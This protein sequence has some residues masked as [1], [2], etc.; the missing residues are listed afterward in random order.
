MNRLPKDIQVELA[1]E[2]DNSSLIKLCS[3]SSRFNNNIC[4]NNFFWIK[5]LKRE[6]P[7]INI[8]DVTEHKKLYEY[9]KKRAQKGNKLG[10]LNETENAIV[11]KTNRYYQF[12]DNNKLGYVLTDSGINFPEFPPEYLI[13]YTNLFNIENSAKR[14][15]I[16]NKKENRSFIT[17]KF[18]EKYTIIFTDKNSDKIINAVLQNYGS[19]NMRYNDGIFYFSLIPNYDLFYIPK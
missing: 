9:L 17:G 13:K 18:G 6:Y 2:L 12:I 1:L 3:T 11:G 8:T 7:N 10:Q 16:N 4:L 19:T 15:I 5:K 14:E